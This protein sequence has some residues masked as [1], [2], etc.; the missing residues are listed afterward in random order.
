MTDDGNRSRPNETN[1]FAPLSHQYATREDAYATIR[2]FD[3]FVI[4]LFRP[5]GAFMTKSSQ[6]L[7]KRIG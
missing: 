2:A 7:G 6:A 1:E 5:A 3:P 4:S